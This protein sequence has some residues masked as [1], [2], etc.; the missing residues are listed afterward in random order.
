MNYIIN[1]STQK[2]NGSS[3]LQDSQYPV[4]WII[5]YVVNVILIILSIWLTISASVCSN[6]CGCFRKLDSGN[7]NKRLMQIATAASALTLPRLI[8]THL[9][10]WVGYRNDT[11]DQFCEIEMDISV[12][13]SVL[14]Y[15]IVYLFLWLR[16]QFVYKQPT[17]KSLHTKTIKILSCACLCYI[18]LG[19]VIVIIMFV[20]PLSHKSTPIG[21]FHRQNETKS[22][23]NLPF[24]V[25]YV[26]YAVVL[27]SQI[28]LASLLVYPLVCHRNMKNEPSKKKMKPTTNRTLQSNKNIS[29][30]PKNKNTDSINFNQTADEIEKNLA[31]QS[32]RTAI[33]K[34]SK[35]RIFQVIKRIVI[36]TLGCI[37]TDLI[38]QVMVGVV[39]KGTKPRYFTN[40]ILDVSMVLN[41]VFVIRSFENYK[42]I[43]C[44]FFQ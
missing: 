3:L 12:T 41:V 44:F 11:K 33:F 34:A 2:E 22:H 23:L 13:F 10:F 15:V 38:A 8:L 1:S 9:L 21:C 6:I 24:N 19:A 25:Y 42:K 28:G 16:Q 20:E 39:I 31:R 30:Q 7:H 14:V 37:I 43:F 32:Q 18:L 35:K 40:T 36:C 17:I 5:T 4:N 26:S 27:V 29:L